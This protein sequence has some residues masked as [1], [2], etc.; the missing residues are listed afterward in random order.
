MP[1]ATSNAQAQRSASLCT[2]SCARPLLM[3]TVPPATLRIE[4]AQD[5]A[6]I[7]HRRLGA[8]LCV[9]GRAGHGAGA[10]RPD[11]Q[12]AARIHLHDA[13]AARADF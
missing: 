6:R 2:A 3:G 5:D 7:R 12:S 11:F 13:A 10:F 9:T 1:C 8:A 4:I